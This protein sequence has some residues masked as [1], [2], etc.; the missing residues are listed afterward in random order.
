MQS[1]ATPWKGCHYLINLHPTSLTGTYRLHPWRFRRADTGEELGEYE[2]PDATITFVDGA[3]GVRVQQGLQ[4]RVRPAV[5]LGR[6]GVYRR[7]GLSRRGV[8]VHACDC[9]GEEAVRTA[10]FTVDAM[11]SQ[12][13]ESVV[14]RLRRWGAMVALIGREQKV[15]D[16]PEYAHLRGKPWGARATVD[17]CRGLG[18]NLGNPTCSVGEENVTMRDDGRYGNESILVHELAHSVMDLGC[19]ES[20]LQ[21]ELGRCWEAAKARG[22]YDPRSYIIS[23]AGEYWAEA[24][25][26]WFEATVRTDVTSGLTTREDVQRADPW[27]ASLLTRVYGDGPW[28]YWHTSPAA[29][30]GDGERW[31]RA[32]AQGWDA[33]AR[34]ALGWG[35]DAPE[36]AHTVSDNHDDEMGGVAQ[37]I[38]LA[39]GPPAFPHTPAFT[40]TEHQSDPPPNVVYRPPQ[41]RPSFDPI[42]SVMTRLERFLDRI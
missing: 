31:G 1:S 20:P 34:R 26:A 22:S 41:P 35:A 24:S 29:F 6:W 3:L 5:P 23:N 30:S 15:T 39:A 38:P 25:Q 27:L 33:A 21:E 37:G 7:R 12:S 11:L 4:P 19:A 42:S 32:R 2:G 9:V 13:P 16:L 14:A 8:G 36:G 40:H 18:G 10:L 17:D 28:R